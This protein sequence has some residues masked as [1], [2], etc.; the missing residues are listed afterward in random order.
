MELLKNLNPAQRVAVEYDGGPVLILAGAGSGKTRVLTH[1]IAYLI[2]ERG[3]LPDSIL[4][5]TF[6]NKA[7]DEMKERIKVLLKSDIYGLWIGT[8][9]SIC[10][11]ILRQEL[12]LLGLKG[13][14]TIYDEA[15]QLR[16]IKECLQELK[17]DEQYFNPKGILSSISRAK[18]ALLKPGDSL[19]DS[20][21]FYLSNVSKIYEL[22]QQKLHINGAMDFCDLLFETVN[23]FTHYPALLKKYQERFREILVDE[24]QDTNRAQYFLA[25]ILT[26]EHSNLWV[27]GDE[28][29]S[30]YS[31]RGAEVRNVV[32]LEKDYPTI[33]IFRLEQNYRSTG[34][35]LKAANSLVE[36]NNERLGKT[37]WT[38]NA[39]GDKV[40]GH[41][42]TN[43]HHE[44]MTVGRMIQDAVR[45][46][47]SY[48]DM[49]VFYRTNAQTRVIEE[50]FLRLGIPHA[51][52]GGVKFYERM[53]IKDI[54]AYL[55][56]VA[57]PNDSVSVKRIINTPSRGIGKVTQDTIARVAAEEKIP[58]YHAIQRSLHKGILSHGAEKR[59]RAFVSLI[60]KMSVLKDTMSLHDLVK[61]ILNLSGY[62]SM[63]E[64]DISDGG[65]RVEN[66]KEFV[67]AVKDFEERKG[68]GSASGKPTCL[69]LEEFLDMV[70]LVTDL[71]L[72]EDGYNRVSLMTL[73][74]AKG[75]EFP[76]VFMVGLEER[77]F[78]HS[79][80]FEE[81]TIEEE[82]RL[83]YVGMTRAKEQLSLSGVRERRVFGVVKQ[84]IM[85]R[86]L[87][88][89]DSA[90]ILLKGSGLP[91]FSEE[92]SETEWEED[93]LWNVGE[94]VRHP[95][96]GV[97]TVKA[98]E[99]SEKVTVLFRDVGLKK[100]LL[101]YTTLE[102][103]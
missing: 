22:Y 103:A 16:L 32:D 73:H 43:E 45:A 84:Q 30:I 82:R 42:F 85:S 47:K 14:F 67:S 44:A 20:G 54:L 48:R 75:L 61:S 38:K 39:D 40:A 97:G 6:T 31:W 71:D 64:H 94:K 66:I 37:L 88:E 96:F 90:Y 28:D 86:F 77:L 55:R 49:A 56:V 80:A 34:M 65:M 69:P 11:R 72:H 9:H 95:T 58:F 63:W 60:E 100:L 27:V 33:K 102:R 25:R 93:G 35:I 62:L 18:D 52:I 29:Q 10:L 46:G 70:S 53:E 51:V 15:D 21:N 7:A 81:G 2:Q 26:A 89:I 13:D 68:E 17:L 76:V 41:N 8:F 98:K 87:D 92:F 19:N 78:P 57:N 5:V 36:K 4:A 1:R 3:Y 99:G 79:R 74:T 50:E 23:L 91:N 59:V 24:F 12:S 83:C 101:S